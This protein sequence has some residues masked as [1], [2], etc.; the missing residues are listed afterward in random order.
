MLLQAK[1]LN[2]DFDKKLEPD[3]TNNINYSIIVTMAI[4]II[5]VML[6]TSFWGNPL[7]TEKV[8]TMLFE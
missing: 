4:V 2:C 7:K 3:I 8:Y 6:P 1:Y 5:V